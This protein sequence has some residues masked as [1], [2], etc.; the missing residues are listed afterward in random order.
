MI[1][2][3]A[4]GGLEGLGRA[5]ALSGQREKALQ[6]VAELEEGAKQMYADPVGLASV[7][8]ELGDNDQAVAQLEKAFKEGPKA[9]SNVQKDPAFDGLRSDKRYADLLRR[10]GLER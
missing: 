10:G 1:P 3:T 9:L 8:A 6:V 5:Y 7:Y 2:E 4:I